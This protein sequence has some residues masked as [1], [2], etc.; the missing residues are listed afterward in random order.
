MRAA[1][2]GSAQ[3]LALLNAEG[4][5]EQR[6]KR[7]RQLSGGLWQRLCEQEGSTP[8]VETPPAAGLVSFQRSDQVAV[9]DTVQTLGRQG[10]WIRDLADPIC[11]RAC[12]HLCTTEDEIEHLV[13][14]IAAL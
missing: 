8:L 10:L 2:G 6:L 1:D 11:L 4:T 3:L 9:A 7:I 13:G 5:A 14:G 12:T